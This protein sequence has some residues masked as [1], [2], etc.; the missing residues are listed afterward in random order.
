MRISIYIQRHSRRV[1]SADFLPQSLSRP[2]FSFQA[3][4][5]LLFRG[6]EGVVRAHRRIFL[7]DPKAAI[8]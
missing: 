1:K 8:G 5:S 2:P 3:R 6:W 7:F 4:R